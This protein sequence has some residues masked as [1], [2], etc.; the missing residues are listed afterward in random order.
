MCDYGPGGNMQGAPIYQ[1]GETA[2]EC[3]EGTYNNDGLCASNDKKGG[4]DGENK[5]GYRKGGREGA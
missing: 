5:V 2:S 1:S 3:P 4:E